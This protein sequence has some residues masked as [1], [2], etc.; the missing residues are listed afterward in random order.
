MINES[1][2]KFLDNY[3][4]DLT[5]YQSPSLDIMAVYSTGCVRCLDDLVKL[6]NAD[7]IWERV[8][9]L[10]LDQICEELGRRVEIVE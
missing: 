5:Q 1:R 8:D 6:D 4:D 7:M 3:D 9:K 2:R 10:T